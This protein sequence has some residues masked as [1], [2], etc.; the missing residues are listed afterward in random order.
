MH[1]VVRRADRQQRRHQVEVD[2]VYPRLPRAPPEL[3]Q[4]LR[5][6]HAP[7]T[8]HGALV[9]GG[10]KQGPRGVDGQEG[11]GRFVRLDDVGDGERA[12]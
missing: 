12:G 7:D 1:R 5:P 6:G 10:G 9:R 11:Y 4:L 3:V 8:D 2:R